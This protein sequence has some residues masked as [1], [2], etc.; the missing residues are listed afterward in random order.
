MT[1]F[2]KFFNHRRKFLLLSIICYG[3]L[4]FQVAFGLNPFSPECD[5]IPNLKQSYTEAVK[6]CEKVQ[7]ETNS[8]SG[9]I[10][11]SLQQKSALR[12]QLIKKYGSQCTR[13][14]EAG[15]RNNRCK[16]NITKQNQVIKQFSVLNRSVKSF[17]AL[18]DKSTPAMIQTCN[19]A[20]DIQ[21]NLN[22]LAKDCLLPTSPTPI[23]DTTQPLEGE[24][25]WSNQ[26]GSVLSSEPGYPA[27]RICG[28]WF[29]IRSVG[30]SGQSVNQLDLFPDGIYRLE[31]FYKNSSPQL[32]LCNDPLT[33][34]TEVGTF[35]NDNNTLILSPRALRIEHK[36]YSNKP[37]EITID[38]SQ[39]P[40]SYRVSRAVLGDWSSLY[41]I[42][43][44]NDSDVS[45][46]NPKGLLIETDTPPYWTI[47]S[48]FGY[49]IKN[50]IQFYR[51]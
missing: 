16:L 33:H 38:E 43:S 8:V 2:I 3:Q 23:C 39:A 37:S 28:S 50:Y 44:D 29:V 22:A 30:F 25:L 47:E 12:N 46:P 40:R 34:R 11:K 48:V 42:Y 27:N 26:Y 13:S 19:Q 10:K 1:I 45:T 21:N 49:A 18:L 5:T 7:N 35:T 15:K 20:N 17:Q 31:Y 36:C 32:I 6:E 41:P 51:K 4:S 9:N 24:E 14:L